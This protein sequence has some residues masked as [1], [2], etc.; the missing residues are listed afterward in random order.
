MND[1]KKHSA[2]LH[3]GFGRFNVF[4]FA[5]EYIRFHSWQFGISIDA[6]K[7]FDRY[8]DIEVHAF[9]FGIGVRFVLMNKLY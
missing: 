5:R 1:N 3:L 2:V 9:C 8:L 4:L 6:V 7:G